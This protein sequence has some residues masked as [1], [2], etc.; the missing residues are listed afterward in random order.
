MPHSR[1][2][3]DAL[4]NG[5]AEIQHVTCKF[6]CPTNN[7]N[8]FA[9]K[10]PLKREQFQREIVPKRWILNWAWF[11]P[12]IPMRCIVKVQYRKPE[13]LNAGF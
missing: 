10:N 3:P 13:C 4:E 5:S 8:K 7:I 11:N 2:G 9:F 12:T 1:L 6:G